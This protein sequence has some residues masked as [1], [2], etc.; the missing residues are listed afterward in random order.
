MKWMVP[1]LAITAAVGLGCQGAEPPTLTIKSPEADAVV[2]PA[3]DD[4]SSV[5]VSFRAGFFRLEPPGECPYDEH[6]GHAVLTVDGDACNAEG[7]PYNA[8]AP[9]ADSTEL[10]AKLALCPT[11][12]GEHTL[13]V[14]LVNDGGEE[15]ATA[16]V[17]VTVP[18]PPPSISLSSLATGDTV[19]LG[20]DA[21]QSV[22]VEFEAANLDTLLAAG[23]C[24]ET[25]RCAHVALRIDGTD[26]N[27]PGKIY[28]AEAIE[29]PLVARFALCPSPAGQHEIEL[30]IH[31]DTHTPL[32]GEAATATAI[33]TTE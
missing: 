33:L 25:P 3:A 30:A 23:G 2:T 22:E 28:N 31:D 18:H 17:T 20:A 27:E 4:D 10:T 1:T 19:T 29:S 8:I 15:E 9:T 6:C 16:S 13:T 5:P 12:F 11:Y 24:G 14:T 7:Q 32:A 21:D 26:C